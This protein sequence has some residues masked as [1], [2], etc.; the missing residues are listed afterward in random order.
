MNNTEVDPKSKIS[1]VLYLPGKIGMKIHVSKKAKIYSLRKAL[2][3]DQKY[4]L[5]FDG[6]I[7][8]DSMSLDLYNITNLSVITAIKS[9]TLKEK[10]NLFGQQN[11]FTE[12]IHEKLKTAVDPRM[13]VELLRLQDLEMIQKEMNS[14]KYRKFIRTFEILQQRQNYH[15]PIKQMGKFYYK[16]PKK[17]NSKPLP[18]FW[19]QSHYKGQFCHGDNLE[20][21]KRQQSRGVD[22]VI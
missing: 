21:I 13:K 2:P 10:N 17:P 20:E 15:T 1:I 7:L 12:L 16:R 14:K 8:S 19:K 5:F 4:D 22:V 3:K 6:K 9:G 11:H 18:I